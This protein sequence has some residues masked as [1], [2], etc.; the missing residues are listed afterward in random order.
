MHDE[1][2]EG[3]TLERMSTFFRRAFTPAIGGRHPAQTPKVYG[4]VKTL[5][6]MISNASQTV[7][8]PPK[9]TFHAAILKPVSSAFQN[10]AQRV[11]WC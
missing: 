1:K 4:F 3:E 9:T 10:S 11:H 7:S 8:W 5:T 6:A 2:C